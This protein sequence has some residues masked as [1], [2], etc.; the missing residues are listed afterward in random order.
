MCQHT[1]VQ[2]PNEKRGR[3]SWPA[4]CR[5]SSPSAS[6]LSASSLRDFG[7]V[8]QLLKE[9]GILWVVLLLWQPQ[10]SEGLE[11]SDYAQRAPTVGSDR[12]SHQEEAWHHTPCVPLA[13]LDGTLMR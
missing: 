5:A 12:D 13:E 9:T 11:K 3:S 6:E 4:Q 10:G 1:T 2:A 8:P 7:S